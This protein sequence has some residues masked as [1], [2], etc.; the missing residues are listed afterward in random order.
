[1]DP[2]KLQ[3]QA[4]D[5]LSRLNTLR[6]QAES[7]GAVDL[8]LQI[9]RRVAEDVENS[10][11][12]LSMPE[13]H[14]S[15]IRAQQK[16]KY[17]LGKKNAKTITGSTANNLKRRKK[18]SATDNE[19]KVEFNG[20]FPKQLDKNNNDKIN[21]DEF[22]EI[23]PPNA[24]SRP[25][26]GSGPGG[27]SPQ[28]RWLAKKDADPK[29]PKNN[30]VSDI[31]IYYDPEVLRA[32]AEY[33]RD[34]TYS[35]A[36]PKATNDDGK[37]WL[38]KGTGVTE[39]LQS[40]LDYDKRKTSINDTTDSTNVSSNNN[41]LM[42]DRNTTH[43]QDRDILNYE[44]QERRRR[45][46]QNILEAERQKQLRLA[47]SLKQEQQKAAAIK[48]QEARRGLHI[49]KVRKKKREAN[50][51]QPS[52]P[53]PDK[54]SVD[55]NTNITQQN[56]ENKIIHMP[57]FKDYHTKSQKVFL[58]QECSNEWLD[59]G[60][61]KLKGYIGGLQHLIDLKEKQELSWRPM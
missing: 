28:K 19:N 34:K 33:K 23:I 45:H 47:N 56:D 2:K 43:I 30:N 22:S 13:Q 46:H 18:R 44:R 10:A 11:H 50:R 55:N 40:L 27:T 3:T 41:T 58:L 12:F 38:V 8:R 29:L 6:K 7:L 14:L 15:N 9:Q 61:N 21:T 17:K 32:K 52:L 54:L 16:Y 1:M 31:S 39:E 59:A 48:K 60:H 26:W 57:S 24:T 4:R 42:N 35:A 49:K 36:L 25:A 5:L 20:H 51:Q 53:S 37:W